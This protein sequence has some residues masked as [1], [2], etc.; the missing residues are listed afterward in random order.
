MVG[1]G[2]GSSTHLL[3]GSWPWT[4]ANTYGERIPRPLRER[5]A[6]VEKASIIN[7][8]NS[9]HSSSS[10]ASSILRVSSAGR[11]LLHVR[12]RLLQLDSRPSTIQSYGALGRERWHRAYA[13]AAKGHD[14]HSTITSSHM[15]SIPPRQPPN[16]DPPTQE[17][18]ERPRYPITYLMEEE[19]PPLDQPAL[20]EIPPWYECLSEM[21]N[22]TLVPAWLGGPDHIMRM[23]FKLA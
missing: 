18:Q 17:S 14:E 7:F 15:S 2:S 9:Q 6:P 19:Y 23:P 13:A 8:F 12:P 4:T 20:E 21:Q 5:M 11:N 1:C 10:M 16:L 22:N 3:S